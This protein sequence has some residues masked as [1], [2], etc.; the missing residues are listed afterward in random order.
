MNHPADAIQNVDAEQ[1]AGLIAGGKVSVVDVRTP[2][3]FTQLGHI[4]GARLVP[5]DLIASGAATLDANE[6]PLLIVCEHG[7]R[8]VHAA[9]MLA[10]AG[11][12][13][14]LNMTG[15]MSTWT[16]PRDFTDPNDSH[17]MPPSKRV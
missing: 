7:I 14:L 13:N 16:G 12:A 5:V 3:E 2:G 8:S 1:A 6:K 11:H 10:E 9:R 4:P 17:S 15:G